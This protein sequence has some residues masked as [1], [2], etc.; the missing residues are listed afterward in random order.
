MAGEDVSFRCVQFGSLVWTFNDG[1]LP[2]N[3]LV[4]GKIL[5]LTNV[6]DSNEGYYDCVAYSYESE[7][8]K[9]SAARAGLNVISKKF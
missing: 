3:S 7:F 8:K 1:E 9:V 4:T 5:T 6:Q 2:A